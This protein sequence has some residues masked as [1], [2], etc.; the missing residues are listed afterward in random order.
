[1]P[2]RDTGRLKTMTKSGKDAYSSRRKLGHALQLRDSLSMHDG[3]KT[4]A[5]TDACASWWRRSVLIGLEPTLSID[6]QA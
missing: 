6:N 1:M 4:S 3:A 2:P 5:R